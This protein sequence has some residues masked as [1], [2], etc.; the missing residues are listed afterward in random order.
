MTDASTKPSPIEI[1]PGLRLVWHAAFDP[2]TATR[3]IYAAHGPFA[4]LRLPRLAKL[5]RHFD[6]PFVVTAGSIFNR[7]V[8]NNPATWRMATIFRGGPK[9]S[10]LKRLSNGLARMSGRRHAHY[11]GAFDRPLRKTNVD[12]MVGE[13]ARIAEQET[14]AWPVDRAVDLKT[15]C[16]PLMRTF[17]I[18]LL[19]GGDRKRALP[20]A[21]DIDL[22]LQQ[23]WTPNVIACP[24]NVP[25][26]AYAKML[27]RAENLE[28]C[29]LDWANGVRGRPD[30]ANLL[31]IVVNGADEEGMPASDEIIAGHI[32]QLF[33]A[34]FETCQTILVSALI[35]VAQHPKVARDLLDEVRGR[36]NGAAAS[37]PD[38]AQMPLLDAVI[39]ETLR[40]LPP[41]P[42]L[43]RVAT[44]DTAIVGYP[45]PKHG[46][47]TLNPF[48]TNRMPDLYP[49]PD[50]FKPERW[51]T[52]N[53][54][55]F[56]YLTFGAGLRAC[57]GYRFAM[58]A[59]KLALATIIQHYRV[60]LV[61]HSSVSYWVRPL[62]HPASEVRA[63]L[64]RQDGAFQAVPIA[65]N[66][67]E[68]VRFA[69]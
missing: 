34:T 40:I 20:I 52:I 12:K 47:V 10:A 65:G 38:L 67:H 31:S 2:F 63:V 5:N 18:E 57:P 44:Q 60:S 41:V 58:N 49:D 13:M 61:P 3:E 29:I 68:F 45:V 53:P 43:L 19:F 42:L 55:V 26:T 37:L 7:E 69:T 1:T 14:A 51:E 66:I 25:G 4:V 33:S 16:Y 17:S 54:T 59:L 28:H 15:I 32:P 56:E 21:R 36:L 27:R 9:G 46:R 50:S 11:R 35:L 8:L 64:R 30:G 23:G 62:L 48:L 24:V 22:L 39:T 6:L